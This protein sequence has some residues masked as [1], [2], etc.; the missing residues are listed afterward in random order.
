M[1]KKKAKKRFKAPKRVKKTEADFLRCL[2]EATEKAI[3][4]RSGSIDE[5]FTQQAARLRKELEKVEGKNGA[6]K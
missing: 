6:R 4:G 5:F 3:N 2:L 1:P